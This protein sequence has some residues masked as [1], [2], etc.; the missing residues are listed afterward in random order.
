[1]RTIRYVALGIVT[2][3]AHGSTTQAMEA[4]S[5]T[6]IT[7][8]YIAAI[9]ASDHDTIIDLTYSYQR[10]IAMIKESNPRAVWDR[11]IEEY[12]DN[13]RKSLDL[14]PS[15]WTD[16][17]GALLSNLG[18]P[19][20]RIRS[21]SGF[22]PQS[23]TWL[24][25][26]TRSRQRRATPFSEAFTATIVYVQVKYP[27]LAHSPRLE[28]QFLSQ[29]I[30]EFSIDEPTRLVRMVGRV[31]A[32]DSYWSSPYSTANTEFL[33]EM[34]KKEL[35]SPS[36]SLTVLSQLIALGWDVAAP[37]VKDLLTT[38]PEWADEL[39]GTLDTHNDPEAPRI[40]LD[41]VNAQLIGQDITGLCTSRTHGLIRSLSNCAPQKDPAVTSFLKEALS[42]LA[43]PPSGYESSIRTDCISAYLEALSAVDDPHWSSFQL[44]PVG[45]IRVPCK[46][47]GSFMNT[48]FERIVQ[49]LCLN[50]ERSAFLDQSAEN[51][52]TLNTF[53]HKLSPCEEIPGTTCSNILTLEKIEILAHDTVRLSG[54]V[55]AREP[56]RDDPF[57]YAPRVQYSLRLNATGTAAF[58]WA[59]TAL[60]PTSGDTTQGVEGCPKA[61]DRK[62]S[63]IHKGVQYRVMTAPSGTG[64]PTH[65]FVGPGK[66]LIRD[67]SILQSLAPAAW[68]YENIVTSQEVRSAPTR[69]TGILETSLNLQR[70]EDVQD[71]LVRTLVEGLAAVSTGGG[72]LSTAPTRLTWAMVRRHFANPRALL[73]RLGQVGMKNCVQ[74]YIDLIAIM[75]SDAG[76]TISTADVTPLRQLFEQA[77]TEELMYASL[78][79][80]LMPEDGQALID[81]ALASVATQLL[82]TLPLGDT[83]LTLGELVDVMDSFL[84]FCKSAD[85]LQG[86]RRD[87]SL[88]IKLAAAERATLENWVAKAIAACPGALTDSPALGLDSVSDDYFPMED[89]L[90]WVYSVGSNL[91]SAESQRGTYLTRV[92]G[93]EKIG[94]H[95]Y[96]RIVSYVGSE[97][98]TEYYRKA[99]DG[100]Y[101]ISGEDSRKQEFLEVPFPLRLGMSWWMKGL[102]KDML[103]ELS[104]AAPTELDRGEYE[105]VIKMKC[106]GTLQ[107]RKVKFVSYLAPRIGAVRQFITREHDIVDVAMEEHRSK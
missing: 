103:C 57:H 67:P 84:D 97:T 63:I 22:L 10:E 33:V 9:Q 32:A 96:Y 13:K 16:Y 80:D 89:G 38:R 40:I 55:M 98:E 82:P 47:L 20:R 31:A 49:D 14:S 71:I 65:I 94:D 29:T 88:G 73:T 56:L 18:D 81:Q 42:R 87:Y 27:T 91:Q 7:T 107:E 25:T 48:E 45:T 54:Q 92:E 61:V 17:A 53:L 28:N 2:L 4:S 23:C 26:E 30:L 106:I 85:A 100:V 39:A 35:S 34:Y 104:R 102:N 46:R 95:H 78:L 77:R 90:E 8:R 101:A 86:F 19:T 6:N 50:H 60:N 76:T 52:Q 99:S 36:A 83:A 15:Y 11:L 93:L 12:Y 59:V 51:I 44:W 68:T 21:L 62:Y 79:S 72:T 1:M 24:V 105:D 41:L 74:K 69:L 58:P 70:Y 3:A 75:P 37:V 64:Q 5:A 43:L 66:T